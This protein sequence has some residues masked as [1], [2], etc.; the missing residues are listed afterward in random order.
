M[1]EVFVA[2][3]SELADGA[4]TF[5]EV[6]GVEV[7]V[8]E[9]DGRL[10]AYE[11]RCLHQ[12]G[13]ACEG[14]LLE[15]VEQVLDAE[16]MARGGR[17]DPGDPHLVCPWHGWEYHLETGACVTDERRRLRRYEVAERDGEVFV[18]A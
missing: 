18:H 3:R 4:R 9:H 6:G 8:L 11:N 14:V 1:A 2:R 10:Y 5:V 15:R 16:G 13:P 7:G 17:L 12:G